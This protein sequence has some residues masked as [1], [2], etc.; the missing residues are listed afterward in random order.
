MKRERKAKQMSRS[1]SLS[2]QRSELE[3]F[4]SH[5]EGTYEFRDIYSLV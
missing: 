5:L 3:S 2:E 4:E 1:Q